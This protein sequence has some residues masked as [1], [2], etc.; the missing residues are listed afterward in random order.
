MN[1]AALTLH[2]QLA[3]ADLQTADDRQAVYR[4]T[5]DDTEL[6]ER[7]AVWFLLDWARTV[8]S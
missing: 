4:Y 6:G 1:D 8:T 2:Y 7:V 5:H 3:T